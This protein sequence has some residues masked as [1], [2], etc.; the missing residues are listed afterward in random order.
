MS[1]QIREVY[2]KAGITPPKGKGLH[3]LRAHRAVISYLKK[4][5]SKEEA[6]KR[7]MGG[8]GRNLVVKKSH[9]R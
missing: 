1:K 3:T 6:W 2:K 9:W 7:V 8:M 4:G 5:M